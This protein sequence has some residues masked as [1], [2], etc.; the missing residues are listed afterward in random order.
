MQQ[1]QTG[2]LRISIMCPS[3]VKCLH[4]DVKSLG[5]HYKNPTKHSGLVQSRHCHLIEMQLVPTI[6]QLQNCS[7]GIKQQLLKHLKANLTTPSIQICIF[8]E[9]STAIYITIVVWFLN[10]VQ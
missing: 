8:V 5:L 6:I 3:G 4:A 1:E 9:I 10:H 7:H 2:W